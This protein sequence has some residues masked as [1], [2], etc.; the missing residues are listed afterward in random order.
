[1]ENKQ[2]IR[3]LTKGHTKVQQNHD[4]HTCHETSLEHFSL[5]KST[6]RPPISP[7][8]TISSRNARSRRVH[9]LSIKTPS[10]LR[11]LA[12]PTFPSDF[13]TMSVFAGM[14]TAYPF[15]DYHPLRAR[16]SRTINTFQKLKVMYIFTNMSHAQNLQ[17]HPNSCVVFHFGSMVSVSY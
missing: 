15:P 9:L 8:S 10:A 3:K 14:T 1:M 6:A 2:L 12:R 13:R 5:V 7:I 4:Y 16:K 17:A 11:I